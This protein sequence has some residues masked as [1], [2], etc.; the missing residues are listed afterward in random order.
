MENVRNNFVFLKHIEYCEV[1]KT[2]DGKYN[3]VFHHISG[4]TTTYQNQTLEAVEKCISVF[5]KTNMN[6]FCIMQE[7]Y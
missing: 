2:S 1:E 4:K 5:D 7:K 6:Y 3:L